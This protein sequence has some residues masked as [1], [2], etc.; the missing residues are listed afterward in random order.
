[1]GSHLCLI[2]NQLLLMF[3]FSGAVLGLICAKMLSCLPINLRAALFIELTLGQV[4]YS[5]V[6]L[7]S[8]AEPSPNL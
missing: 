6:Y 4:L 5:V 1:M 7:D 8:L 2:F 3:L